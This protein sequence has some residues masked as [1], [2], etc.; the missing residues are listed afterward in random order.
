M[1]IP[2]LGTLFKSRDYVNRQSEL[3]V[4]VTP[5]VVR[6]SGAKKLSRPDDGF[7]DA[8]DPAA[9]SCS[10]AST[11]STACPARSSRATGLRGRYGFILD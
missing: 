5:Y 11:G 7:A 6:A 9:A 2:V 4:L 1:N 3:V 10:A 8:A